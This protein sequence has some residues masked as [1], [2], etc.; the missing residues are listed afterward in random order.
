[1]EPLAL[2]R[3]EFRADCLL[4]KTIDCTK[5]LCF[6]A[7]SG[8]GGQASPTDFDKSCQIDRSGF[9]R[10]QIAEWWDATSSRPFAYVN[11]GV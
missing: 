6:I 3:R 11:L 5:C 4:R 2:E 8:S 7:R 1:M 9:D 10:L